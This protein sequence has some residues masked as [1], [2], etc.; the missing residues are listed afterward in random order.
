MSAAASALELRDVVLSVGP[1][2]AER[3][4]LRGA[5]LRVGEGEK[6]LL[7]G[8]DLEARTSLTALLDGR[9]PPRYGTVSAGPVRSG[10]LGRVSPSRT[11]TVLD[12]GD[13][14]GPA[15]EADLPCADDPGCVLVLAGSAW[16][17]LSV[18]GRYRS[19]RL[20]G[21]QFVEV[22]PAGAPGEPVRV[23]LAEL[24]A[25]TVEALLAAGIGHEAAEAA[26]EVLVDAE[27]RGH[28]SHGIALLPTYLR[29][30]K[31]GGIRAEARPRLTEVT[32]AVAAIDADGGIGQV[33]AGMAAE[34]CASR[35]ATHGLAAVAVHGNNHVG[36]L[37]AYRRPFQERQ[38]AG[39]LLNTSGPSIAAPGAA[40]PTLGSNAICLVTP[41]AEGE[42]FCVDLA[43]G[44]VAA[45]KIRDA[46]NR[47]VPVPPGWLQDAS[48]AATTDPRELDR[49]GS[50]PLF[51]DYKGL[52]VTLLAEILA[53]ALAGHRVSPDVGKQRK[54]LDRVMNCS[55]LFVG[56]SPRHLGP[57]GEPS[58]GGFVRRL[59]E[60]VLAGHPAEPPRPWFPDQREEDHAALAD[61][62]GAE[63][64]RSVLDELGWG[65]S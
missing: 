16:S 30:I 64:P 61:A 39:L 9:M 52:C 32:P 45:G 44:V 17:G 2:G 40:R 29:R 51:G 6:V 21:G 24:Q 34:W 4:L 60:A 33:A 12:A 50:I 15:G 58:L 19:L 35:A 63:V 27:R 28:R 38:V 37:A 14:P 41:T 49:D 53:G 10:R 62:R 47:G 7:S 8:L 43:T 22:E 20:D 1:P 3:V 48:G 42:P 23:P 18:P 65:F 11:T 56:F 46:A 13:R 55:Q 31:E 54:H 25:R 59:R 5:D 26:G 36:M 57:P